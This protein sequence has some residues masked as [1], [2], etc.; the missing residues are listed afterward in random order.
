MTENEEHIKALS[1]DEIL[2]SRILESLVSQNII[3]EDQIK[4]LEGKLNKGLLK[5]NDWESIFT[6]KPVKAE[7]ESKP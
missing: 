4:E 5:A 7:I 1:P 3:T 2:E 6:P